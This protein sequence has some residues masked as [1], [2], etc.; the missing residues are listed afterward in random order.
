MHVEDERGTEAPARGYGTIA[1]ALRT[2]AVAALAGLAATHY[3]AGAGAPADDAVRMAKAG[4]GRTIQDPETTG[5]ISA[6]RRF[7]RLE[8][9]T[10]PSGARSG[11]P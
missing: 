7:V 6:D 9:C 5:A 2:T 3:L 11:R 4:T 8:P 10:L 1:W